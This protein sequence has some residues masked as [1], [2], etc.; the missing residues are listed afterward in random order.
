MCASIMFRTITFLILLL[1][2]DSVFSVES[3][4]VTTYASYV[5]SNKVSIKGSTYTIEDLLSYLESQFSNG[6]TVD[7][8]ISGKPSEQKLILSLAAKIQENPKYKG[9]DIIVFIVSW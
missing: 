8:S 4:R 2:A 3:T 7:L 1:N 9:E 6:V 5:D